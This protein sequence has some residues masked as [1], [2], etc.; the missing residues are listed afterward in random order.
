MVTP[1]IDPTDEQLK[2]DGYHIPGGRRT[3]PYEWEFL[4]QGGSRMV[5]YHR[6]YV[7]KVPAGDWGAPTWG[8]NNGE[9]ENR[10]EVK[11]YREQKAGRIK[12]RV[13]APC[14]LLA[15]G[16]LVMKAVRP[17]HAVE[18]HHSPP[19]C[20]GDDDDPTPFSRKRSTNLRGSG[21]PR[22]AGYLGD[23]HQVGVTR[24]GRWY[25]YDYALESVKS[26]NEA[27]LMGAYSESA[28]A[29]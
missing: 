11:L 10:Q 15:N 1:R 23:V 13:L 7:I 8:S 20:L 28:Q 6:G 2:D 5:F 22:W 16:W 24:E 4:G 12:G 3:V 25:S 29:A 14:R 9:W 19:M 26:V 17:I 27:L 18:G 21:A